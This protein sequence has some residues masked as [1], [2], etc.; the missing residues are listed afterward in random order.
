[1]YLGQ[2]LSFWIAVIAASLMRILLT[3]WTGVWHTLV[4]FITA[5]FFAVIFTDPV[6]LFLNLNPESYKIGAAAI[7]AL[8]GEGIAKR[9]L[10]LLADPQAIFRVIQVWRGSNNDDKDDT[11]KK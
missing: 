10:T 3:P 4:S 11:A 2:P 9:L 6:L 8:T 1:M 5:I 7:L